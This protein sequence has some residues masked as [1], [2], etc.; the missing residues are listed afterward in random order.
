MPAEDLRVAHDL[1]PHFYRAAL[2]P[3]VWPEVLGRFAAAMRAPIAQFTLADIALQS[4]LFTAQHGVTPAM[5]AKWL[6]IRDH[7]ATD[8]RLMRALDYPNRPVTER[9][10]LAPDVWRASVM[11]REYIRPFGLGPSLTVNVMLEDEGVSGFLGVIRRASD[12]DYDAADLERF[13]L[14]VPH[15][16]QAVRVAARLHRSDARARSF[17]AM[18]DRLRIAVVVTDRFGAVDFLNAPAREIVAQADGLFIAGG[19]LAA[20]DVAA[21]S[22]LA[23]A[24]LAAIVGGAPDARDLVALP[25]RRSAN[26]LLVSVAR[27]DPDG[28]DAPVGRHLFASLFVCDPDRRY[29]GDAEALQRV[30]GLTDMEARVLVAVGLGAS[31]REIAAELGNSYE[32]VRTH[33]KSLFAK[34]GARSQAGLVRAVHA[35]AAP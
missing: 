31:P 23:E 27:A 18:F 13:H 28:E 26:P 22:A 5:L 11:Y 33:L 21:R 15:L 8:V 1:S 29:E 3:A 7:R 16:R 4:M 2:E 34:T 20:T 35:V 6:S 32:T 30:Y 24:I 14:C 9:D 25:R 19:R 12:P 10:L 17:A